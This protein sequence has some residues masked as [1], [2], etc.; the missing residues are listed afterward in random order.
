MSQEIESIVATFSDYVEVESIVDALQI[1]GVPRDQ[2][3]VVINDVERETGARHTLE[4]GD[5][6]M[7]DAGI[8]AG[9]GGAAGLL[10]GTSVLLGTGVGAVFLA[11]PILTGL[12]G[13]V[14]GAFL[15][16]L[17]GWG[18]HPD[19]VE[20]YQEQVKAGDT[21]II[22][23]GD[24]RTVATAQEALRRFDPTQLNLHAADESDAPDI[25]TDANTSRKP[26]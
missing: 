21:L 26:R 7:R 8:G 3:S 18:V 24:P 14:V 20:K 12:T 16:A 19:H 13:G 25:R 6:D 22:V 2:I 5:V 15:G 9:I 17:R 23:H 4:F 10:V 1:A 11:G